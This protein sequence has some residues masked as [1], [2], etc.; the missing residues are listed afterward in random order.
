MA[1]RNRSEFEPDWPRVRQLVAKTLR[2]TEAEVQAMRD[3]GDSLDQ[4]VLVMA[5]EEVMEKI[6]RGS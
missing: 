1:N 3:R 6:G 2:V 5:A 4:V